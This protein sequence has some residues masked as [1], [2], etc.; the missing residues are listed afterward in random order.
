MK[1]WIIGI[2]I[3]LSILIGIYVFIPRKIVITKSVT[4]NASPSGVYRFLN[5]ESNWSKWWPDSSSIPRNVETFFKSGEY[6]F[7]KTKSL[8]NSFEI[9]IASGENIQNSLLNI[10]PYGD[11][12]IKIEWSTV[13]NTGANPFNKIRYYL[14]AEELRKSFAGILT[15]MQ[16]YIGQVKNIYGIDIR[17][18]KV[19]NE[20]LISLKKSF[21]RYP[22]IENIYEMISQLKEYINRSGAME[23]DYP[24]LH[25]NASDSINFGVQVAI[26]VNKKLPD[27]NIFSS[28]W[29]LKNG[30]ILAAEITGGKNMTDSAMKRIDQYISD[31]N[32]Q[33]VAIPFQSLVTDRLKEP[34]SSKWLTKIYYP[35]R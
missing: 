9:A 2:S 27:T 34:D 30:N 3:L 5:D 33:I 25:I 11:D 28:K 23:E 15:A 35:I 29:M 32:Y 17:R 24:M 14:K 16:N 19:K 12:S 6:Q 26:P 4:A 21:S 18:E 22:G 20:F 31:Y 7:K 13:I 8:F 1:K 10:F